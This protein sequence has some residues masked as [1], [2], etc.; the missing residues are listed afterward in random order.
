[1][2]ICLRDTRHGVGPGSFHV[3]PGVSKLRWLDCEV[4]NLLAGC[5]VL[6]ECYRVPVLR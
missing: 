2:A 6:F 5:I 4:F 3:P 1:M